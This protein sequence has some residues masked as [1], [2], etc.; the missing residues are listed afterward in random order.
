MT[1]DCWARPQQQASQSTPPHNRAW[2]TQ[3]TRQR[4]KTKPAPIA[5]DAARYSLA[6]RRSAIGCQLAVSC[7][8]APSSGSPSRL[9]RSALSRSDCA[10]ADAAVGRPVPLVTKGS[11]RYRTAWHPR[12]CRQ[13]LAG[14]CR[15]S[16]VCVSR[17]SLISLH[18]IPLTAQSQPAGILVSTRCRT[19]AS[20]PTSGAWRTAGRRGSLWSSALARRAAEGV[21]HPQERGDAGM[22]SPTHVIQ[23]IRS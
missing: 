5:K 8:S 15:L 14:T 16:R 17:P 9:R 3:A 1:S 23:F 18:V 6:A 11:G 12:T 2:P 13:H 22:L 4:R 10:V 20:G 7:L 21:P 19:R